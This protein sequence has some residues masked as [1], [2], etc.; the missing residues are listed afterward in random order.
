VPSINVDSRIAG[1]VGSPPDVESE[2]E[3]VGQAHELVTI[4]RSDI[5]QRRTSLEVDPLLCLVADM[6]AR[7]MLERGYF[8]HVD[9]DDCGPNYRVRQAGYTL[10]DW[11][12]TSRDGNTIESIAAGYSTAADVWLA[13]MDSPGHRAHLLGEHPTFAAQTRIGVGLVSMFW[14]VLTAPPM[15]DK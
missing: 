13:W 2:P 12:S 6:R 11:Y 1:V 7:D 4:M 15:G 3:H 14:V 5:R 8:A 10:P 9:L